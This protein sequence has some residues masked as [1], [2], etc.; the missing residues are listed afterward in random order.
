MDREQWPATKERFAHV[1][2]TRGRDEWVAAAEGTDACLSPV[3]AMSEVSGDPHNKQRATFV[4][5]VGV[6][7]PAPAPRFEKTPPAVPTPPVWPGQHGRDALL[8]W[9]IEQAS[10]AALCEEGVLGLC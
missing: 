4:E 2:R 1:F 3:L 6:R 10:I 7:Q 8:S 9:G 5:I